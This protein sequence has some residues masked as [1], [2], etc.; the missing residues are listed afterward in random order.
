MPDELT[1]PSFAI[2]CPTTAITLDGNG[3]GTCVLTIT[4]TGPTA[5]DGRVRVA[6][7]G[8]SPASVDWLGIVEPP[9]QRYQANESRRYTF[10]IAVPPQQPNGTFSFR[11]QAYAVA[12][13]NEDFVSGP[14]ITF[15]I[16]RAVAAPAHKSHWILIAVIVAIVLIIGTVGI[17]EVSKS[18]PEAATEPAEAGGG[19]KEKPAG[20]EP[21]GGGKTPATE[22]GGTAKIPE[23]GGRPPIL[24]P[25]PKRVGPSTLP[26]AEKEREV[27]APPAPAGAASGNVTVRQGTRADLEAGREC[28]AAEQADGDIA[29]VGTAFA[30]ALLEPVNGARIAKVASATL[31]ACETA[32]AK[33]PLKSIALESLKEGELFACH[34]HKGL[35]VVFD[36]V[37]A[38][39]GKPY[40]V[41]FRYQ[42]VS[43]ARAVPAPVR[44]P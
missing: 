27:P 19:E 44:R 17:V 4:N 3:K 37:H 6:G 16:T 15:T 42:H 1:S 41:E 10:A 26:E 13:P 25:G 33:A 21:V 23:P 30:S 32:V 40:S 12:N 20:S 14:D 38:A 39:N 8:T 11:A 43:A 28:T 2:D 24:E 5:R 18:K 34:T 7:A 35:Y 22:P 9:E 29:L 36:L 31:E